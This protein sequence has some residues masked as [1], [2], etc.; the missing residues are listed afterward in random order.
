MTKS[1][2]AINKKVLIKKDFKLRITTA[3]QLPCCYSRQNM[4]KYCDVTM[5]IA[6]GCYKTSSS[7]TGHRL[8]SII[9]TS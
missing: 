5:T 7:E 3:N 2:K 9:R 6:T 8:L 4:Y 1:T